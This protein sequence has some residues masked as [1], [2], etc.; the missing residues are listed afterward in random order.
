MD[1]TLTQENRQCEAKIIEKNKRTSEIMRA[2]GDYIEGLMN[3][4]ENPGQNELAPLSRTESLKK[5][6]IVSENYEE[7]DRIY[8]MY[9]EDLRLMKFDPEEEL[10]DDENVPVHEKDSCQ[11]LQRSI[12]VVLRNCY[13]LYISFKLNILRKIHL[14]TC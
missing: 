7:Y 11:V 4:V 1:A 10:V 14:F 3:A 6:I 9:K 5:S 12:S 2:S 8:K 13:T